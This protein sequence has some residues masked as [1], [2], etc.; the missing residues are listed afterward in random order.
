MASNDDKNERKI[1]KFTFPTQLTI[2]MSSENDDNDQTNFISHLRTVI[3]LAARK[4]SSSDIDIDAVDKIVET[5]IDFVKNILEQMANENNLSSFSSVDLLNTIR[6]NPHLIPSRN[7]YF[8]IM[9][10]INHL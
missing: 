8:S 7:L 4:S 1:F 5:T 10:T 3:I 2:S 9:E 6:L